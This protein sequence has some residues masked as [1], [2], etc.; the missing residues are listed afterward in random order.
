MWSTCSEF[1]D[2]VFETQQNSYFCFATGWIS[3]ELCLNSPPHFLKHPGFVC[4]YWGCWA[5]TVTHIWRCLVPYCHYYT[6]ALLCVSISGQKFVVCLQLVTE[7]CRQMVF[8]HHCWSNKHN[9]SC[10]TSSM[11][12]ACMNHASHIFQLFRSHIFWKLS[13]VFCHCCIYF[14][15]HLAHTSCHKFA[16]EL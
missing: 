6:M 13:R 14:V 8:L 11:L 3:E 2:R 12:W 10:T 9:C 5:G 16:E 7:C 15:M 4:V 1:G